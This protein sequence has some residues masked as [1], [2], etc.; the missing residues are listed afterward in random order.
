MLVT[1]PPTCPKETQPLTEQWVLVEATNIPFQ[2]T[3][4]AVLPYKTDRTVNDMCSGQSLAP[5]KGAG[6]F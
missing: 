4:L 3:H 6:P 2:M 1:C 5:Q